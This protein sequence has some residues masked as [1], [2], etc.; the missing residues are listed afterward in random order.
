M[1]EETEERGERVKGRIKERKVIK[2]EKKGK[3]VKK[4]KRK[5]GT[6]G[7]SKTWRKEGKK[8]DMVRKLVEVDLIF[9]YTRL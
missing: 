1:A 8:V 5:A 3:K 2:E 4:K 7:G 9:T 6:D